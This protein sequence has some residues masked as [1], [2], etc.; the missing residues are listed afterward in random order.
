MLQVARPEDK[1]EYRVVVLGENNYVTW[2][3][4]IELI[5]TSKDLM[6]C[7]KGTST[8]EAKNNQAASILASSMSTLN[9]QRVVNCKTAKEIWDAL[10]ATYENKSSSEKTSLMERFTSYKIRTIKDVSTGIGELQAIAARLRSLEVTIDDEFTISILLRALP[11]SFK[12]WK[13]TWKL[14]N[15]EKPKLNNLITGIMAEIY[16]MKDPEDCAF[17]AKTGGQ[18]YNGKQEKE[19]TDRSVNPK[20]QTRR[21]NRDI[22]W[23]CKKSGHWAKDCPTRKA[24]EEESDEEENS[25]DENT[26]NEEEGYIKHGYT[27]MAVVM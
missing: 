1:N 8:S 10:E 7:I 17:I 27:N 12:T 21:R 5:L 20:Q 11:E 2:K 16:E 14:V 9:M 4:Q 19:D 15:A 24:D 22:C 23:Y 3:W 13:S 18:C 25:D 6:D 26:S